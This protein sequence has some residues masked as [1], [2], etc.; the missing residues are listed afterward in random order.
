MM[1][2]EAPNRN[3]MKADETSSGELHLSTLAFSWIGA[4]K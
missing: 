1:M 2:Q 3:V 4:V